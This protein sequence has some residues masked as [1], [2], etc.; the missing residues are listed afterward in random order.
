VVV[1][2]LLFVV[3]AGLWLIGV[4][5]FM[6]L[7]PQSALRMLSL[8]ASSRMVNNVEQGLRFLAGLNL[9][10]RSPASKLPQALEG[11]GWFVILSSLLLLVLPLRWHS[12]YPLW[13]ERRLS[14]LAVRAIATASALSGLGFIYAAL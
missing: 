6:A 10:L 14:P 2:G 4:D 9:V 3:A 13:W 8:T 1:V 12:A 5:G 11:A 7:R